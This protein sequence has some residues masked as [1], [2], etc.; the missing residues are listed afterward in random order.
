MLFVWQDSEFAPKASYDLAKKAP[1]QMF[2]SA[3][4]SPLITSKNL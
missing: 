2:D 1:S 4:N 3:L